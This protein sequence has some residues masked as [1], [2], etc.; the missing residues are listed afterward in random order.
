MPT[1]KEKSLSDPTR[2]DR[3]DTRLLLEAKLLWKRG[4]EIPTDLHAR[5]V[6]QGYDVTTLEAHY[7]V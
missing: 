5:L 3:R 7:C 4:Q 1:S 6:A 2:A